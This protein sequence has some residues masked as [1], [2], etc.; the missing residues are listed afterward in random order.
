MVQ[1]RGK[2]EILACEDVPPAAGR[3]G[4]LVDETEPGHLTDYRSTVSAL[5]ADVPPPPPWINAG[6]RTIGPART[7]RYG[8]YGL[9]ADQYRHSVAAHEM[10]HAL[11]SDL[12]ETVHLHDVHIHDD[13]EG[14]H[15]TSMKEVDRGGV[16]SD[17]YEMAVGSYAGAIA[18]AKWLRDVEGVW[19]PAVEYMVQYTAGG[20]LKI[21]AALNLPP[22]LHT[23]ARAEA[24]RLVDLH[25]NTLTAAAHQLA[26]SG[27]LTPRQARRAIRRGRIKDPSG[28]IRSPGPIA[29]PSTPPPSPQTAA[30]TAPAAVPKPEPT[31]VA[32]TEHRPAA[33]PV[34]PRVASRGAITGCVG[35]GRT[36]ARSATH[37][38]PPPSP[39]PK[40]VPASDTAAPATARR[41]GRAA[42]T[43]S[44]GSI[45]TDRVNDAFDLVAGQYEPQSVE[46]LT[47]HLAEFAPLFERFADSLRVF[48]ERLQDTYG[49]KPAVVA[50]VLQ[51]GSA[52]AGMTDIC[53]AVV[54]TWRTEQA[55][56]IERHDSPR[57]GEDGFW[58]VHPI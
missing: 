5:P 9:T 7:D 52:N 17:P 22:E 20:D 28:R 12:S 35:P 3:T 26:E 2:V 41:T 40:R 36:T 44:G 6:N 18:G 19:T 4:R 43:R 34:R 24:A 55:E 51:F 30:P 50:M 8:Q 38:T 11:V 45:L 29:A 49:V 58:N 56:D 15:G 21:A 10:G 47:A 54:D 33:P 32:A 23:Q 48:G 42:S 37:S 46:E 53:T 31:P 16:P 27:S 57:P 39:K 1:P 14:I 13:S 25:W